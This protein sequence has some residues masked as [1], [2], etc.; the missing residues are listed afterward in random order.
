MNENTA[1]EFNQD[2]LM[3]YACH[4]TQLAIKNRAL[5]ELY[6][7]LEVYIAITILYEFI[8]AENIQ[9]HIP[10][11]DWAFLQKWRN[12][13][14][15][16]HAIPGSR[17]IGSIAEEMEID[18]SHYFIESIVTINQGTGELLGIN[19]GTYDLQ[20]LDDTEW[21]IINELIETVIQGLE[22]HYERATIVQIES[23][24]KVYAAAIERHFNVQHY[25][26]ASGVMFKRPEPCDEDKYMIMYYYT[27]MSLAYIA[28]IL[29]PP[30]DTGVD[31]IRG[32][33]RV[34][35]MKI[36]AEMI[37]SFG[38]C[39][40]VPKTPLANEI[41]IR[42]NDHVDKTVFAL[43]R[44]LR[45]NLHYGWHYD[46]T[47]EELARIDR[48]QNSYFEIVMMSFKERL[49]IKVGRTYKAVMWIAEH[50][51]TEHVKAKRQMKRKKEQ[52][53]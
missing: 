37:E 15:K 23:F 32:T 21:R 30:L 34:S 18:F 25:H 22:S 11:E 19:F 14:L 47:A 46:F 5:R 29:I 31:I 20:I 13:L 53:L 43:N 8:N 48:F 42:I 44:S 10:E 27:F 40:K 45:N 35:V 39:I 52:N 24:C 3:L 33:Y 28:D 1:A 12:R 26:Y 16:K 7:L 36:K 51:D 38:E 49:N 17:T 2:L 50:T 9:S 6:L 41:A 4:K